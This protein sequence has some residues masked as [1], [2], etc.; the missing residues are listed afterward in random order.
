MTESND[1]LI[2]FFLKRHTEGELVNEEALIT[3][4]YYF[5]DLP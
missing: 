4:Q 1:G 2:D 5:F 3:E